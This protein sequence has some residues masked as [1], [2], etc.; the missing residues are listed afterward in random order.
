MRRVRQKAIRH[1]AVGLRFAALSCATGCALLAPAT[2]ALATESAPT[3]DGA[4]VSGITE[5]AATIEAQIN[6]Q[7][8]EGFWE[9]RLTEWRVAKPQT[10]EGERMPGVHPSG[11]GHF[12]AGTEEMTVAYTVNGLEPGYYYGYEVFTCNK[13][14]TARRT[15]AFAFHDSAPEGSGIHVPYYIPTPCWL[16]SFGEEEGERAVKRAE[17]ERKAREAREREAREREVREAEAQ[18]AAERRHIEEAE[19]ATR[20]MHSAPPPCTVP[21]VRG[22]G[23]K[24]A[25]RAIIKHHCRVGKV[26]LPRRHSAHLVVI[27]QTPRHG[28]KLPSGA[29]IVLTMGSP[30]HR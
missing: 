24:A 18:L 15:D 5:H 10:E 16:R 27:G 7:G 12:E 30:R 25:R 22:Q 19:A 2:P 13:A 3:I 9:L 6:P 29:S 21:S 23:L 8:D 14:G 17:E 28:A 1:W 4:A 11:G 20:A 26:R